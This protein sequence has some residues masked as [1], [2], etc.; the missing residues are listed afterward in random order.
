M[1][2]RLLVAHSAGER[3]AARRVEADV[4]LQAFGN[5][6]AVMEQEYGPYEDRSR[7][8]AV[9]DDE[10]GRALGAI[11]LIPAGPAPV[12]T[13]ADVAGEPWHLPV[14]DSLATIDLTPEAVWDVA[15]LAVDPRYRTGAAGAEITLALCHGV[16]RYATGTGVHGL[17]TILDDRVL[18]VL[19]VLGLPWRPMAGASSRPYLGSPASTPCVF[20][21]RKA[22]VEVPAA[23]PDLVPALDSGMFRSIVVDPVD[24]APTRGTVAPRAR[25]ERSL[26][27]RRDTTGWRPPTSRR[28]EASANP[29]PR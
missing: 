24:L 9:V 16:W 18:R 22:E 6:P 27:P 1:A 12:K 5:T 13:L 2:L 8:V 3:D 10:S 7:F 14:A 19:R 11:R 23:R 17:V 25:P 20:D 21:L 4:F 15:S 26:P 29:P 28:T